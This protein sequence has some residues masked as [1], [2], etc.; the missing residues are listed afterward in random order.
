MNIMLVSVTERTREIGVRKRSAPNA[1]RLPRS[2]LSR[3]SLLGNWVAYL[4]FCSGFQ[5]GYGIATL[6]EFVFVTPWGAIIA[7]FVTT[8]L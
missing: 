3:R 8:F 5:Y 7:A 1:A 4:V 6:L 2:F